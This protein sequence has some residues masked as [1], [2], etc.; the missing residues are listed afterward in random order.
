V[1]DVTRCPEPAREWRGLSLLTSPSACPRRR[2]PRLSVEAVVVRTA[3]TGGADRTGRDTSRIQEHDRRALHHTRGL[4]HPNPGVH[5]CGAC[6]QSSHQVRPALGP[7]DSSR[8]L[9][10]GEYHLQAS[11]SRE[12]PQPHRR[13]MYVDRPQ[14]H[15]PADA[16]EVKPDVIRFS[17]SGSTQ[18]SFD[19]VGHKVC[20]RVHRRPV[21]YATSKILLSRRTRTIHLDRCTRRPPLKRGPR[22]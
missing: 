17:R 4:R 8:A 2:G 20:I 12:C 5:H 11:L 16:M 9:R 19:V 6:H 13:A 14:V 3:A 22:A 10:A 7:S 15:A 1:R 18:A 21:P